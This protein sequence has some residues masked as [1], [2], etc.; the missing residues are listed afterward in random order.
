MIKFKFFWKYIF[1]PFTLTEVK[2]KE[3]LSLV[4]LLATPWT[5]AL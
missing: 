3:L 2:V 4:G 1:I 5:I